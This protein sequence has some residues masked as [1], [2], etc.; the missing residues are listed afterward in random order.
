VGAIVGVVVGGVIVVI[1]V[2]LLLF[3]RRRRQKSELW[4]PQ[5]VSPFI[6]ISIVREATGSD[7]PASRPGA[8]NQLY[9]PWL[10][11]SHSHFVSTSQ[12]N[13]R[14]VRKQAEPPVVNQ[15]MHE[16]SGRRFHQGQVI[17]DIPPG[18]SAD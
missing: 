9:D 18:Y 10:N 5:A 7:S 16:D 1:L 2:L 15:L 17:E 8:A 3:L 12:S 4:S 6:P 11:S 13:R 14:V